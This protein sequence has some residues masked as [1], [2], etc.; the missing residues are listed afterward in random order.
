MK[1]SIVSAYTNSEGIIKDFINMIKWTKDN[2]VYDIEFVLVNNGSKSIQSDVVDKLVVNE[3][4]LPYSKSFNSGLRVVSDDSDFVIQISND[5]F[6]Y[7]YTWVEELV[8]NYRFKAIIST[9]IQDDHRA[10]LHQSNVKNEGVLSKY[11]GIS[12]PSHCWI[13]KKEYLA[14]YD[15]GYKGFNCEDDD[16]CLQ[17]KEDG[18]SLYINNRVIVEHRHEHRDTKDD[19][20]IRELRAMNKA[21]FQEKWKKYL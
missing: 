2:C 8:N 10:Y 15:E 19:P 7:T 20:K 17:F 18:G 21:R 9:L 4:K 5:I 11:G 6:P 1:V 13:I 3:K 12:L 16:Y 14:L